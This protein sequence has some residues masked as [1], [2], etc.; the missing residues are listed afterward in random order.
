MSTD[1]FAE[2]KDQIPGAILKELKKEVTEVNLNQKQIK[3]VLEKT[4]KAY[5]DSRIN[6]GEAIGVIT[7]ESF[8]EPSTQMVLNVFHFAGVSEV[9]VTLGLPRLIEICDARKEI[10]TPS[11]EIYLNKEYCTDLNKVRKMALQIKETK[12]EEVVS[13][14]SVD[15]VKS[16]IE[17]DINKN[18]LSDIGMTIKSLCE[19]LSSSLK[20]VSVKETSTGKISIKMKQEG[21]FG[22]VY[23][24]K[25]KIKNVPIKGIKNIKQILPIKKGTEFIVLTAG[26]NLKDVLK[27]KEVDGTRT[28][29]ND[30]FEINEVLGIEAARQAIIKEALKVIEDQ[31]LDIDIRHLMF[32]ADTMTISGKIKGVTRSGI[33]SE[34]ES[35]LARASFETP[36][37]HLV[38]ASLIG[39]KDLLNSVIE[40]VI[41]NQ[42]V[43][44]GTGL[45]D[46]VAKMKGEN[47]KNE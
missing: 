11:M 17:L 8:G 5:I 44:L 29:T 46:L 35:V 7:A 20:D 10:K 47:Q 37:K 24:L 31:G 23:K 42:P 12:L 45:P 32:L 38:N 34:K 21:D 13:E 27:L 41:L 25:E 22:R 43:P 9:Q 36:I 2:F 1:L 16:N 4:R 15:L 19:V 3:E 30:I 40:N 26:T 28:V 6:P 33:S 14:I 18:K 39:E